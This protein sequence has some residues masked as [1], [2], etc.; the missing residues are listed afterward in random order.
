MK[1]LPG[2]GDLPGPIKEQILSQ[3]N[4]EACKAATLRV[5]DLRSAIALA[6]NRAANALSVRNAWAAATAAMLT[7]AAAFAAAGASATATIL[8]IPA[9]IILFAIMAVLL[10]LA[11]VFGGIAA[12]WQAEAGAALREAQLLRA[13]FVTATS[14]MRMTCS[15]YCLSDATV[16]T[17]GTS[18]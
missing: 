9:A 15:E 16:P 12:G 3:C 14:Q 5:D 8:G 4:S 13:Q 6:C 7:A 2:F 18:S 11:A 10:V 1:T 17:C